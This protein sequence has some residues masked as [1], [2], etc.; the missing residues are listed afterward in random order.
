MRVTYFGS[1]DSSFLPNN[2]KKKIT[3]KFDWSLFANASLLVANLTHMYCKGSGISN[4]EWKLSVHCAPNIMPQKRKSTKIHCFLP[5]ALAPT[6]EFCSL[7]IA[8]HSNS[9]FMNFFPEFLGRIRCICVSNVKSRLALSQ[10]GT[11][12]PP[13][14]IQP[15]VMLYQALLSLTGTG[16]IK[17]LK[18]ETCNTEAN[19]N[20]TY[21]P[22]D[23]RGLNKKEFQQSLIVF[24]CEPDGG[25]LACTE[26]RWLV[27]QTHQEAFALTH[28]TWHSNQTSSA[29]VLRKGISLV[30]GEGEKKTSLD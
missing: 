26:G 18:R 8:Q 23:C 27:L 22:S 17:E 28:E 14:Q 21:L 9:L 13:E 20:A 1:V 3:V 25:T 15:H 5:F 24:S 10:P 7:S 6:L 29:H 12:A 4:S 16:G 2:I 30:F 11:S 19:T